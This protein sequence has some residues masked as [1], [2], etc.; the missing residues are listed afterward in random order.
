MQVGAEPLRHQEDLLVG[1]GVALCAVRVEVFR[2][3]DWRLAPSQCVTWKTCVLS[4]GGTQGH[5]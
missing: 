4:R 5:T 3:S 1:G 2:V